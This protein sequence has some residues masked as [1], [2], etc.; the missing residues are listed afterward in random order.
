VVTDPKAGIRQ[1]E[2]TALMNIHME[3][4]GLKTDRRLLHPNCS[5]GQCRKQNAGRDQ[6]AEGRVK[7]KIE[8]QFM[9]MVGFTVHL[10][11]LL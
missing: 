2:R 11:L 5:S 3:A 6:T 10:V 1:I 4:I 7:A 8:R 9:L